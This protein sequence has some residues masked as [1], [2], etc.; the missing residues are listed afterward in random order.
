MLSVFPPQGSRLMAA[1][2]LKHDDTGKFARHHP[3]PPT[4]AANTSIALSSGVAT[5]LPFW[6]PAEM[7][8]RPAAIFDLIGRSTAARGISI[9]EEDSE[10]AA[11]I[12]DITLAARERAAARAIVNAAQKTGAA[13]RALAIQIAGYVNLPPNWDNDGG[14]APQPTTASNALSFLEEVRHYARPPRAFVV[15]DG[16][17]GLSWERA[18][19]Y[20]QISFHGNEEIVVIAR[21]A[22]GKRDVRG[23]FK[24]LASIPRLQLKDI[25][26]SL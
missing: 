6:V 11:P 22:D 12:E 26:S 23:G 24:T 10:G 9:S 17:I 2:I 21:S 16:E 5:P 3:I 25:I 18:N 7:E 13:Y 15:G 1:R 14:D 20:A 4:A 8:T 19:G